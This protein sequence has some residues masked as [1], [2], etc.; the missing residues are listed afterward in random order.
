MLSDLSS[1]YGINTVGKVW[2]AI[3]G[4]GGGGGGKLLSLQIRK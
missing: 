4:W 1:S 2:W 3:N